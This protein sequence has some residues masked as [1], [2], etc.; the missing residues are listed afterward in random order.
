MSR[1]MRNLLKNLDFV[2]VLIFLTFF[3]S[4]SIFRKFAWADDWA[5][6]SGYRSETVE[7]KVE[8]YSGYRPILQKIMDLSF[9]NLSSYEHLIFLRL[10]SVIGMAVLTVLVMKSLEKYGYSRFVR[11]TLGCGLNLLPTFWIYTNWS[12]TFI[13]PWVCVIS[14]LS[15][16]LFAKY[17]VISFL[18]LVI[19]FMIYQPAAVFS[20]FLMF[21]N[22][23]RVARFSR[24]SSSYLVGIAF[25][26]VTSLILSKAINQALAVPAK[27][28]TGFLSDPIEIGQKVIWLVTR[29]LALSFRP[30]IVE[31]HG[32]VP[33]ALMA[34]GF[35]LSIAGLLEFSNKMRDLKLL[36]GIGI[37]YIFGLLPMI[38]IAEN[39]IEFRILPTTSVMGLLLVLIGVQSLQKKIKL[40]NSLVTI[41]MIISISGTGLYS[42]SKIQ[43]IFIKPF[44]K[45]RAY[46]LEKSLENNL[47]DV[48]VVIDY[49]LTWPQRNYIGALSVISDF[50]MPWVPIGE[51]SQ[52]LGINESQ[53]QIVAN[54]PIENLKNAL[55]ID[56]N[57]VRDSL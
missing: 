21:A 4:F 19:A 5:F 8:H 1:V 39:Q 52:V 3:N 7:V 24:S 43:E 12:S 18:L 54:R 20:V 26:A 13:Y 27:A 49:N 25:S 55:I 32:I 44:E 53:I 57:Q 51:V 35:M 36:A 23:L 38:P 29:P 17:K 16:N 33:L 37:F 34:A 30:F 47:N 11:V 42:Q 31:S 41:I 14:I 10:L 28:R 9:G 50:Q 45:N 46:L 6:I 56:L 22:Y 48:I 40:S 15:L 2:G